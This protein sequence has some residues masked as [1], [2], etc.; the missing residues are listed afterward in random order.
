MSAVTPRDATENDTLQNLGLA[1]AENQA[2][3][4][5]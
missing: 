5:E 3:D 1:E 2:L 4:A